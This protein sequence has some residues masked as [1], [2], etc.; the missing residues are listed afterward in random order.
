M[1]NPQS[2][3][4]NRKSKMIAGK[5][6]VLGDHIDTDQIIPAKYLNLVP[7][8][9][10]EYHKLGSYALSGLPAVSFESSRRRE[11]AAAFRGFL[12]SGKPSLCLS[13]LI[14]DRSSR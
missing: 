9:P 12:N 5:V 14:L 10:A 7:T 13:R 6:Y 4:G 8:I 3:I 1:T 2:Q 11:P